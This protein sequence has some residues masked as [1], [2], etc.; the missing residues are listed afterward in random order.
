MT[1]ELEDLGR[2]ALSR[3]REF[4]TGRACARRALVKL[5]ERPIAIL[6]GPSGEPKWPQGVVG[7]ITHC[8]GYYAAA[9]APQA[10]VTTLGIDAEPHSALPEGV[11]DRIADAD[12]VAWVQ[13]R[14]NEAT[15]WDRVLFSAKESVYKAWFPL[16]ERWLGFDDVRVNFAPKNRTFCAR[17]LVRGP[18]IRGERLTA[19]HGRFVVRDGLVLTAITVPSR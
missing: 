17:L 11:L 18:I 9:V 5:G 4:A 6:R 10:S 2:A 14:E 13:V 15:H 3:R 12:E 8:A 7:S 1:K 16:A 19:F